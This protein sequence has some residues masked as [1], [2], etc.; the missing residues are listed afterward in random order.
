MNTTASV[1]PA[2]SKAKDWIQ[3]NSDMLIWAIV[4]TVVI[5]IFWMIKPKTTK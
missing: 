5:G 4:I 1:A 3:Q 2:G